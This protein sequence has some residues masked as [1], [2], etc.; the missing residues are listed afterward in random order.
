MTCGYRSELDR[1]NFA[2]ITRRSIRHAVRH[3]HEDV[4]KHS[5]TDICECLPAA[6]SRRTNRRP[7]ERSHV[8]SPRHRQPETARRTPRPWPGLTSVTAGTGRHTKH[9]P[10]AIMI[11]MSLRADR[12]APSRAPHIAVPAP[13]GP[14]DWSSNLN[15]DLSHILCPAALAFLATAVVTAIKLSRTEA[16]N[17]NRDDETDPPSTRDSPRRRD[18]FRNAG[19]AGIAGT[20]STR[21]TPRPQCSDELR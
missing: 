17:P 10:H 13:Y 8:D 19:H 20:Q 4:R 5:N 16:S 21:R 14:P 15:I 3:P 2:A 11:A 12:Q 1:D 18:V 9:P 7:A 6:I